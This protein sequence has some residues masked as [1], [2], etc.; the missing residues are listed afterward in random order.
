VKRLELFRQKALS[1]LA[2]PDQLDQV[3]RVTSARG[4]LALL[5]LGAVI[6]AALVWGLV[7]T[8]PTT[9]AGQSVLLGAGG[10]EQVVAT[11]TGLV[12]SVEV[13]RNEQVRRGQVIARVRSLSAGGTK[14][15]IISAEAGR[16]AE[17]LVRPG[18]IVRVGDPAAIL[19]GS[20]QLQAYAYVPIGPG[21]QI[22][23]GMLVEVSPTSIESAQYG[24]LVGH[25][26]SVSDFPATEQS[27]D[28]LLSNA[29]LSRV[30]L[31]GG[32]VLQVVVS[33]ERDPHTVSGYKWSSPD[34]PPFDLTHGTL[35]D[36][37]VV[38][39][40]QHPLQLV[41]GVV[42]LPDTLGVTP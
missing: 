2:S 8:V 39:A 12:V 27:L 6:A 19:E 40:E 24:Y 1:R 37:K 36:A 25:V 13:Q 33:L 3:M 29:S 17:L 30:L 11:A 23:P 7:G 20:T 4:W 26:Q 18:R 5:G 35:A 10:P 9:V 16:V 38:T 31:S 32:P 15:T 41:S 14:S 28:L 22:K 34:G 42:R 21:K